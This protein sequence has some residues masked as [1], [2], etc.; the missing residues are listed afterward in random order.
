MIPSCPLIRLERFDQLHRF[1]TALLLLLLVMVIL[2]F[3]LPANPLLTGASDWAK[4]V[5]P[6]EFSGRAINQ[7]RSM[8]RLSEAILFL[9]ALIQIS[10][11]PH[12][13]R[14]LY[15]ERAALLELS[16][17]YS[18]AAQAWQ[19]AM[20]LSRGA[21]RIDCLRAAAACQLLS[22]DSASAIALASMVLEATG[23]GDVDAQAHLVIGWAEFSL[24]NR[25]GALGHARTALASGNSRYEP[26]ALA[27]AVATA[28]S[29]ER[30]TFIAK[31]NTHGQTGFDNNSALQLQ[32]VFLIQA[33]SQ[34]VFANPDVQ[35]GAV[36]RALD[37][38][39]GDLNEKVG[40][41]GSVIQKPEQPLYYQ[42][43]A[44]HDSRNAGA[45]LSRLTNQGFSGKTSVRRSGTSDITIVYVDAG[46]D[47]GHT[48][49]ALK[50]AGFESWP[51]FTAP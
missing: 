27:L 9:E 43:G 5:P 38:D 47:P 33:A 3:S 20:A 23:P 17:R 35:A 34:A 12:D 42:I 31:L 7:A 4:T 46:N 8:E 10:P 16:G 6:A 22:G 24:G 26:Y 37:Q 48:I 25:T 36:R 45:L 21:D 29:P 1:S 11:Q 44:F 41:P 32:H 13:A 39:I 49:I 30:D 50:D 18:E 40:A 28:A 15:V 19:S 14:S 2:P 51:L